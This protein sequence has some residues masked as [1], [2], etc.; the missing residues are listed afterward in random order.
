MRLFLHFTRA[1][2]RDISKLESTSEVSVNFLDVDLSQKSTPSS[3]A[4]LNCILAIKHRDISVH[5]ENYTRD[6]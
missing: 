6:D 2:K 5:E 3:K 4:Y 1:E